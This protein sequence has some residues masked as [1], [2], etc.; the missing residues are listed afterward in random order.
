MK[1][2]WWNINLESKKI[3][4]NSWRMAQNTSR[5][6]QECH[7]NATRMPQAYLKNASRIPHKSLK[8][9]SSQECLKNP[10]KVLRRFI[11]RFF[12]Q[13][14]ISQEFPRIL[15]E[16]LIDSSR[17]TRRFFKIHRASSSCMPCNI[18]FAE[19]ELTNSVK[20]SVNFRMN[21]W[22]HRFSQ[23]MNEKL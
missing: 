15:P 9:H 8:N 17:I 1:V 13:G 20:R 3:L 14:R 16:L 2:Q 5:M 10:S 19:D 23:N 7:K 12:N 22:S 21:L 6:P 18:Q 4:K 11:K